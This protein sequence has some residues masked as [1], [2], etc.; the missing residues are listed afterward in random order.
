MILGIG[1]AVL[2]LVGTVAAV[3]AFAAFGV[4]NLNP[5]D[6]RKLFETRKARRAT[7]RQHP[8][9]SRGVE[10]LASDGKALWTSDETVRRFSKGTLGP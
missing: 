1:A 3:L 9:P 5:M 7:I 2:V 8:A 4:H 10:D 6:V